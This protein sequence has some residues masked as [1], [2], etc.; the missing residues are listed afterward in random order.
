MSRVGTGPQCIG[1]PIRGFCVLF[2]V[3]NE[4]RWSTASSDRL[5]VA[6]AQL[7]TDRGCNGILV[8]MVGHCARAEASDSGSVGHHCPIRSVRSRYRGHNTFVLCTDYGY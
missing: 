2:T 4:L 1:K 8:R 6:E 7:P 5:G 3:E